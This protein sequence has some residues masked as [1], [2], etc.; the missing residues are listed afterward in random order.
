MYIT[1]VINKNYLGA[2]SLYVNEIVNLKKEPTNPYD[3]EA[4]K[5]TSDQGATYGYV[6]NS[7]HT[8]AKG[9]HSAGYIYESFRDKTTARIVFV[10][11]EMA[12]AKIK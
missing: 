8:K 9:T 12:I 5:V 11:D 1:I 6:A 2:D 3:E 4:I 10:Y 7:V